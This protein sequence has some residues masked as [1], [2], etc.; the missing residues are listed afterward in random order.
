MAKKKRARTKFGY[1][2][3]NFLLLCI[4]IVFILGILTLNVLNNKLFLV[5]IG[6]IVVVDLI[7]YILVLKRKKK[8]AGILFCIIFISIFSFL[9]YYVYETNGILNNIFSHYKV[10][11]YKVV[12]RTD[13]DYKRLLDIDKN[14]MG[15]FN[16][17]MKETNNAKKHLDK[18]IT[19]EYK[20][21]DDVD[22]MCNALLNSEIESIIIEDSY[23][24][25]IMEDNDE[26]IDNT[27]VIYT[28]KIRIIITDFSK[29]VDVTKTPFNI[30]IMKFN[31][32]TFGKVSK[33]SI[34]IS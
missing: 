7:G 2:L 32:I 33:T 24:N 6:I 16:N 25:M 22:K 19:P 17:K 15:F 8:K 4:S 20:E 5:M 14:T 34:I 31:V 13:S 12:V 23:I 18:K 9:S 21:Y 3:L 27:K 1:R 29:D 11:T 30:F 10:Y 26:F 28:F